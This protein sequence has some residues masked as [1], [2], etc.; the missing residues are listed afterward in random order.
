MTFVSFLSAVK[1]NIISEKGGRISHRYTS[2]YLPKLHGFTSQNI[3][4]LG[5]SQ[6]WVPQSYFSTLEC[7]NRKRRQDLA[8]KG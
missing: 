2:T 4:T 3:V 8:W 6:M 1:S 7:S 5:F